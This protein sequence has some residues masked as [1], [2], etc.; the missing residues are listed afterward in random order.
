MT[1]G[2]RSPGY[3]DLTAFVVAA[4]II[5]PLPAAPRS[6]R[7]AGWRYT[8]NTAFKKKSPTGAVTHTHFCRHE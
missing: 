7:S 2:R 1:V 8:H 3:C 6:Y 4:E 5:S